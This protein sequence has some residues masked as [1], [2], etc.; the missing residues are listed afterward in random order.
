[1]FGYSLFALNTLEIQ[2]NNPWCNIKAYI[3]ICVKID[4]RIALARLLSDL[5]VERCSGSRNSGK[6]WVRIYT[7]RLLLTSL[8]YQA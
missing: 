2:N 5:C 8:G 6:S 1:M 7:L 4:D 3:L